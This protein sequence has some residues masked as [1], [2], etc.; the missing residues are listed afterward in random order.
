MSEFD[1]LLSD[2]IRLAEQNK[3]G[4]H[5]VTDKKTGQK[6]EPLTPKL[7]DDILRRMNQTGHV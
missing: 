2:A 6:T 5:T 3:R 4:G 1:R 7:K